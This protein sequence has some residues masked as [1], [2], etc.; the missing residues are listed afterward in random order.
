[1]IVD[2]ASGEKDDGTGNVYD[3]FIIHTPP[4]YH[5]ISI[6][7]DKR[8]RRTGIKLVANHGVCLA[9]AGCTIRNDCG[10]VP[11]R[12][13]PWSWSIASHVDNSQVVNAD[14]EAKHRVARMGVGLQQLGCSAM[15]REAYLEDTI[16]ERGHC[17][18]IELL[19]AIGNV[20]G[21]VEYIAALLRAVLRDIKVFLILIRVE[22][23]HNL[24]AAK[25]PTE[26]QHQHQLS[27]NPMQ[28][29]DKD[30]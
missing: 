21:R 23:H 27:L 25:A 4:S 9:G 6:R 8:Q 24:P 18:L 12:V 17:L 22:C 3:I 29:Q 7:L 2:N 30:E 26:Q 11:L 14:D 10:I 19:V 1:M 20:E 13:F 28:S 5:V 15:V 16:D